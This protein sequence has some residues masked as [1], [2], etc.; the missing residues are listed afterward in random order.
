VNERSGLQP[1]SRLPTIEAS[2]GRAEWRP[3]YTRHALV[4]AALHGAECAE[5]EAYAARL[6][7][8]GPEL[9]QWDAR[10]VLARGEA[11]LTAV[12][13]E[14]PRVVVADR[15]GDVYHV[16]GG[17]SHQLTEP[18]ELEEWLRFIATQCPE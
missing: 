8:A 9:E 6:S 18:R 7:E 12:V 5:C 11:A 4:L 15:F 14:A 10:V 2:P 17:T 3:Q 1:G 13:R 16:A